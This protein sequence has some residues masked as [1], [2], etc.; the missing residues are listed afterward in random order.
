M[1]MPDNESRTPPRQPMYWTQPP[2][3][4]GSVV[5]LV[6]AVVAGVVAVAATATA[7]TLFVKSTDDGD[8]ISALR[9]DVSAATAET[10]RE[11]AALRAAC[12]YVVTMSTYDYTEID[13][14]FEKVLAGSTGTW[15]KTFSE[16]ATSLKPTMVEVQSRSHPDETHCGLTSLDGGTAE[17]VGIVKE[18]R[19]NNVTPTSVLTVS[20]VLTLEEQPDG[21]WLIS[22]LNTPTA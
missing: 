11:K 14:Y 22:D 5:A 7:I 20:M 18:S 19:S 17:A 13:K 10:D 6:F 9:Q 3:S 2:T 21:R 8:T 4:R 15:H 12:D 1:T 16:S